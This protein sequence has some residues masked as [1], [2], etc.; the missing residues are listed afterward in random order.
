MIESIA[1]A[2]N[3][4]TTVSEAVAI[5]MGRI[6]EITRQSDAGTQEAAVSVSYLAELSEQLRAS[7]STFR[8]PERSNEMIGSF[9]NAPAI[10]ELA[11]SNG[12]QMFSSDNWGQPFPGNFP[13]LPEPS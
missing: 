9:G 11:E 4:Q 1:R 10:P 8:L 13:P 2:A 12:G 7:V 5:T 3:E 6:S